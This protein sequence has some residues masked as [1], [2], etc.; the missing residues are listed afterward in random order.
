MEIFKFLISIEFLFNRPK[1]S[2]KNLKLFK[3]QKCS[4]LMIKILIYAKNIKRKQNSKI[5]KC[6]KK[7]NKTIHF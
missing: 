1:S 4:L 5:L 6:D 7:F 2:N 3:K